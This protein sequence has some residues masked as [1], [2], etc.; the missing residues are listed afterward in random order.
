MY[1]SICTRIHVLF[2][3]FGDTNILCMGFARSISTFVSP[4]ACYKPQAMSSDSA[5]AEAMQERVQLQAISFCHC[6]GKGITL[7]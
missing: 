6:L 3:S 5:G 2:M 7:W 4:L 1:I